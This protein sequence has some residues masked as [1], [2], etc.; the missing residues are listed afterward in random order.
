MTILENMK[1]RFSAGSERFAEPDYFENELR[2]SRHF[3]TSTVWFVLSIIFAFFIVIRSWS[4]MPAYLRFLFVCGVAGV[5]SS[6]VDII[7]DHRRVH[8]ALQ[9]KPPDE[10]AKQISRLAVGQVV[11]S[12]Y[13]IFFL[14]LLLFVFAAVLRGGRLL[15]WP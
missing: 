2:C 8:T 7:R 11:S 3:K 9:S 12:T 4:F 15:Q 14:F 1:R 13:T 6:W 5:L 10:V